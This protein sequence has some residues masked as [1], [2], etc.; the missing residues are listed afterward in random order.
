M[1]EMFACEARAYA[2]TA[3]IILFLYIYAYDIEICV[4]G[5][6]ATCQYVVCHFQ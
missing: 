5:I 1:R 2:S 6:K 3:E 4:S